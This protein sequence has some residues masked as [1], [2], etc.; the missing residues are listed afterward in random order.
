MTPVLQRAIT[1]AVRANELGQASPYR[2]SYAGTA[3]SG[4]SFGAL[5]GDV[6]AN[7]DA[8]AT[9]TAILAPSTP[10]QRARW[11]DPLSKPCARSPFDAVADATING[12]IASPAGRALTDAMDQRLERAVF[13][14]VE[15]CEAA[16]G[17]H[18]IEDDALI[19]CALWINMSGMPTTL[20][21]WL[22]AFT[23]EVGA[24]DVVGYL[25]ATDY[26]RVPP[27]PETAICLA[28]KRH[29]A[30]FAA[31]WEVGTNVLDA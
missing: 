6:S 1:A 22:A 10:E 31:S 3:K 8:R 25:K 17:H 19:G 12:M 9:L 24:A 7:A 16:S 23:R 14:G 20:L 11:L 2:L 4:A 28:K 15:Q 18:G 30:H 26:F 29:W 13:L 27:G 21:H 5:Q